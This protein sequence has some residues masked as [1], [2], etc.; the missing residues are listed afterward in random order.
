MSS[1]CVILHEPLIEIALQILYTCIDLFPECDAVKF[2]ENRFVESLAEPIGLRILHLRL[3]V[4]NVIDRQEQL[5]V[6]SIRPP[7]ELRAPIRQDPQQRDCKL[8]KE[9]NHSVI[10]KIG[11]VDGPWWYRA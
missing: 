7:R 3:R 11:R 9:G 1:R 10:E 5:V 2:I 4:L 6:V 8:V